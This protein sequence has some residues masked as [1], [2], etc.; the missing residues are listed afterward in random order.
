MAG[1]LVGIAVGLALLPPA[2]PSIRVQSPRDRIGSDTTLDLIV[3]APGARLHRLDVSLEQA[4][5]QVPIFALP[6]AADAA[7]SEATRTRV[8]SD[9]LWIIRPLGAA[10][11]AAQL[12]DG[13]AT[14]HV[15]AVRP[16][17]FGLR[18]ATSTTTTPVELRLTVAAADP[19]SPVASSGA[20]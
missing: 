2:P 7:P 6:A 3:D 12:V 17:W 1:T 18:T 5:R 16:A 20:R 19:V 15:I 4:G 13:P 10:A 8:T 14:L 11:R 9:R